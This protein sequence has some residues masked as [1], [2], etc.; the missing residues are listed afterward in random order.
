MKRITLLVTVLA[1]CVGLAS[2]EKINVVTTTSDMASIAREIGGDR[3]EVVSLITGVQ[4]PHFVEPRPSMVVKIRKADLVLA[5]GL[6]LDIWVYSLID[7]A[8]NPKVNTGKT[9]FLDLS[10]PIKKLEVLPSGARVDASMGDV[11]PLGNPHYWLDPENGRLIARQIAERLSIICPADSD[12]F[13]ANL[14]KFERRIDE[15]IAWCQKKMEKLGEVKAVSYHRSLSYFC[16][17]FPLK[18]VAELEPK[19]GIPPGPAHLSRVVEL[20]KKEK[21]GL[22]LQEVFY[23]RKAADFVARETGARVVVF[24]NSV[25]GTPEVRDYFSLLETIVSLI[26]GEQQL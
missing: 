10:G 5:V 4:D 23:N 17:R 2:A 13:Q 3:V 21:V 9:G 8:R 12:F 19:P 6:D 22:I 20:M 1:L 7:A 11:H 16:R 14:K 26:T 25:G 15:L 18:I 24:P